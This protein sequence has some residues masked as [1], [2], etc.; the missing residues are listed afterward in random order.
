MQYFA[1][2]GGGV[3]PDSRSIAFRDEGSL[4]DATAPFDAIDRIVTDG[5]LRPGVGEDGYREFRIG[6]G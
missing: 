3:N 2:G 6:Q 4:V 5:V 1:L